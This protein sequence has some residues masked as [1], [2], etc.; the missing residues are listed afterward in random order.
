MD[1]VT[2][3]RD[4]CALDRVTRAED[5][6]V[7]PLRVHDMRREAILDLRD[8]LAAIARAE[9]ILYHSSLY[10]G[11]FPVHCEACRLLRDSAKRAEIALA[12]VEAL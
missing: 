12:R 7:R 5:D 3:T 2:A 8:S 4:I 6:A 1:P 9:S 10:S 11:L